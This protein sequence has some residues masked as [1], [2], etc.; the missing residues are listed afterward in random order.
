[1]L[2]WGFFEKQLQVGWVGKQEDLEGNN[3][4]KIFLNLN[5]VFNNKNIMNKKERKEGKEGRGGE[6]EGGK[7]GSS[8]AASRAGNVSLW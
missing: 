8:E 5:I 3:M 4:I 2:Y 6:R 1:M 7:E